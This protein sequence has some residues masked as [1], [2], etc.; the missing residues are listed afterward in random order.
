MGSIH[1]RT[2]S[3]GEIFL[4]GETARHGG[5]HVASVAMGVEH[6][7]SV[8][9]HVESVNSMTR[10]RVHR[11]VTTLICHLDFQLQRK[12]I[13]YQSCAKGNLV[14]RVVRRR[15]LSR[16]KSKDELFS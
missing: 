10:R 5:S 1:A 9:I 13:R 8:R 14:K 15:A 2:V 4:S 3:S 16:V 7:G 6:S 11:I 12:D